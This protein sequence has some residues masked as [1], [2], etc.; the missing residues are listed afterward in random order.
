VKFGYL[1]HIK[2]HIKIKVFVTGATGFVGTAV[3]QELLENGH[4]VLGLARS[5]ES[6]NKLIAEGADPTEEI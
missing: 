2:K 6:A 4:E 1:I 5:E 3:I